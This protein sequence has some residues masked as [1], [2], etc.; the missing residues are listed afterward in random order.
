MAK[1]VAEVLTNAEEWRHGYRSR[2]VHCVV[3]AAKDAN[4][5]LDLG[6]ESLYYNFGNQW[7]R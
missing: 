5:F 4:Y 3:H 6:L 2:L 7:R 1:A